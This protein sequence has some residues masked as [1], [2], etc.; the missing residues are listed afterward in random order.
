MT[1]DLQYSQN[2]YP[3]KMFENFKMDTLKSKSVT[4]DPTIF[5]DELFKK[6]TQYAIGQSKESDKFKTR[7]IDISVGLDL[8]SYGRENTKMAC[9]V[10]K[11]DRNKLKDQIFTE[12]IENHIG[13][14]KILDSY[15]LQDIKFIEEFQKLMKVVFQCFGKRWY[16][17]SEYDVG[18]YMHRPF[19]VIEIDQLPYVLF[20]D[21]HSFKIEQIFSKYLES[22]LKCISSDIFNSEKKLKKVCVAIPTDFHTYQRIILNKCLESIGVK[23]FTLTSKSLALAMPLLA[24]KSNDSSK[25]LVIDFGSGKFTCLLCNNV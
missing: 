13:N 2:I 19:E 25:K 3:N 1:T 16:E 12:I 6:A 5:L 24:K 20:D 21:E 14:L 17:L 10:R 4:F 8:S 23:E 9:L 22:I 18:N 7:N 15:N 11:Y